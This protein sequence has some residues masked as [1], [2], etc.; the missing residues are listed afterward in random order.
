MASLAKQTYARTDDLDKIV[1]LFEEHRQHSTF[2][3]E[4][5]LKIMLS[6]QEVV[7][8]DLDFLIE[9]IKRH[10]VDDDEMV[11]RLKEVVGEA[12]EKLKH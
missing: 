1:K 4:S 6:F 2:P 8:N 11:A 5:A 3:N 9:Q 12:K 10:D 7:S